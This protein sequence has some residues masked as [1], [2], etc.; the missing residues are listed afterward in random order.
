[1]SPNGDTGDTTA[2]LR[3][4]FLSYS[5]GEYDARTLRMARS[6]VAAGYDVTV[7][8]RQM[9]GLPAVEQRDGY[10]LVRAPQGWRLLIPGLRRGP[11]RRLA[12]AIEAATAAVQT[13][14][15][16]A[17]D[18]G[19]RPG[20]AGVSDKLEETE[21]GDEEPGTGDERVGPARRAYR[22][23]RRPF[24]PLRRWYRL[25]L[26][27]PIRPLQWAAAVEVIAAPADIWHGMWAGSLPAL[28][29]LRARHGGRTIYDSRDVYMLSRDFYRLKW[30]MRS[31]LAGIERRWARAAD[32][33]LTVN[34]S[35]ADLL[36]DGL[37][38]ERPPV[39]LNCPET[40]IPPEPRPDRLRAALALDG[41]TTV[42]LY[43]GQLI[44][45]RGIE[46]AMDA[47]LAVPGAVLVLLG[48]GREKL[49][50]SMADTPPYRGRVFVLPPVP[51]SELLAWT[52]SAD[53]TVM[54]IQPTT[55]N[56]RYTT[57]QKLFESIAA[58]VPVVASDLPAMAEIVRSFGVGTVCDPTS[59][60]A[61]AA[62]IR[63]LVA[64]PE[65]ERIAMRAHVLAVGHETF[66][67]EHQVATL[68]G[69]YSELL[70]GSTAGPGRGIASV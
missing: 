68:F 11:R 60:E 16:R 26:T 9:P 62:A 4:A 24:R 20:A 51:P 67:W 55:D 1:M 54:P 15:L 29:R 22:A 46:Q 41:D 45:E 38:V 31:V 50:R 36:V 48:Y 27:F 32:R 65:T 10:R 70:Q 59:S 13:V 39:V 23:V 42:V 56:H 58:G 5:S 25:L 18:P 14:G 37:G 28:V 64:V 30:P 34:E 21:G 35:Y 63:S 69:L 3:I 49:Y 17:S 43:Q 66:S 7:Y 8:A 2:R 33:V 44:G 12:A 19:R 52:T 57:P 61:I 6:A 47:I 40:W 53:V